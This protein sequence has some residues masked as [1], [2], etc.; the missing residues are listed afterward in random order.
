MELVTAK[1]IYGDRALMASRKAPAGDRDFFATPPWA[2]R[3]LMQHV[4]PV[5]GSPNRD[6]VVW[7]PACGEGHMAAPLQEY[8]SRV[9]ASDIEQRGYGVAPF[10]FLSDAAPQIGPVAWVVSNPWFSDGGTEKFVRRAL[11]IAE[12]GVAVF[13]RLQWLESVGRYER[14]FRDNPPTLIAFFTERVPLSKGSWKPKGRTATA[15]AWLTW[16]KGMAPLPPFWIP[17]GQRKALTR[18]DD[19]ERFKTSAVERGY[20]S[21]EAAAVPIAPERAPLLA[22]EGLAR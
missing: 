10:D 14:L 19:T 7:E 9:M 6:G 12:V 16:V 8:F 21:V 15:Y 4:W 18:P 17:P 13:T 1:T 5:I 11:E 22:A 3:A 20:E 2:T